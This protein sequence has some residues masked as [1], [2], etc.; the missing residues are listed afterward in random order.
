MARDL[1]AVWL[2]VPAD[3]FDVAVDVELPAQVRQH[4]EEACENACAAVSCVLIRRLL[5]GQ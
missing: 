5:R 4:L 2:E 1:V 3:S